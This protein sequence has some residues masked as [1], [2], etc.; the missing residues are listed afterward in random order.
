MSLPTSLGRGGFSKLTE[1]RQLASADAD[2]G[3][4]KRD[5]DADE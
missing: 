3:E 5:A 1:P 4:V 2:L